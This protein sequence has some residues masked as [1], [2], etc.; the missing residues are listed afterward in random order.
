MVTEVKQ[1]NVGVPECS[2]GSYAPFRC[3]YEVR[4]GEECGKP[5]CPSCRINMGVKDYC[6]EH[7]RM[8]YIERG[9][10]KG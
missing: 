4:P 9:Y 5:I 7:A 3:D 1:N 2:S 10:L 8:I 6:P